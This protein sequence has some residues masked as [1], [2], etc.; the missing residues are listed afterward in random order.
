MKNFTRRQFLGVSAGLAAAAT[1]AMPG[2]ISAQNVNDR[3][4]M[5]VIGCGVRGGQDMGDFERTCQNI[6]FTGFA[7]PDMGRAKN[8]GRKHPDAAFVADFRK[9]LDDDNL[10]AVIVTTPDHWHCLAAILAMQAGKDVYVEKPL[11]HTPW[12]GRQVVNAARKYD[13]ICQM[14]AQQFSDVIQPQIQKFVHED[15]ALGEMK[16]VAVNHYSIR[17]PIGKR[18]TPME[19][20]AEI[21]YDMWLGPAQ[22]LPLYRN[23]FHYDWHWMWN[24]GT[25]EMGNWGVHVL[26][27]AVN[28]TLN[29]MTFPKSI[30]GGGA[31]LFY[32]DAGET[33]N[34]HFVYFETKNVPIVLGLSTVPEAPGSRSAGKHVGA[35]SGYVIY[36]EGGQLRGQRG[37]AVAVDNDGKVIRTFKGNSGNGTHQKNFMDA[38]RAHDR[39]LLTLEIEKAFYFATWCNLA[40]IA[41]LTGKPYTDEVADQIKGQTGGRWE[42]LIGNM[43]E[44]VGNYNVTLGETMLS[45]QL[46][47]DPET[48]RF[49]GDGMDFANSLL[50][51]EYRKGFEVP[52]LS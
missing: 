8:T 25:G 23:N 44:L 41:F 42:E 35:G 31:R 16:S 7:D 5:A 9:L 30:M 32:N 34:L 48:G 17:Q 1:V 37:S 24:T 52:D 50:K 47:I 45:P 11:A 3:V 2:R 33:P 46:K 29:T 10:N 51:R 36:C 28:N 12:E 14:G 38:V 18:E 4:N 19:I 20:P 26:G 43:K 27:D 22:D 49:V 21:D 39:S 40:N 15:K 6:D 13:K